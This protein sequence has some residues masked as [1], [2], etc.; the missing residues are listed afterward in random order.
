[1]MLVLY[2]KEIMP[3]E[4]TKADDV[5]CQQGKGQHDERNSHNHKEFDKWVI[6]GF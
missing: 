4:W 2:A 3:E 1:M 6:K 5:A